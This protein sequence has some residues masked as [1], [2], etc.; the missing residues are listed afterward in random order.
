MLWEVTPFNEPFLDLS[1]PALHV[2]LIREC[3]IKTLLTS[4]HIGWILFPPAFVDASESLLWLE[5][6]K[7]KISSGKH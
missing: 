1:E 3:S 2:L 4:L 7:H 5:V 6:L